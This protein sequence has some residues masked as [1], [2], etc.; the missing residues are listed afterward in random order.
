MVMAIYIILGVKVK[1]EAMMEDAAARGSEV[2]DVRGGDI[3]L[4][5]AQAS[6]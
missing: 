5:S 1:I 6:L 3:E 4:V 2:F